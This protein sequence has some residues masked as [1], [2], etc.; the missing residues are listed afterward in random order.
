[1]WFSHFLSYGMFLVWFQLSFLIL[2]YVC[3]DCV[4]L[5]PI[6]RK[7][8]TIT[9]TS[10]YKWNIL[11]FLLFCYCGVSSGLYRLYHSI[12]RSFSDMKS[13]LIIFKSF[14]SLLVCRMYYTHWQLFWQYFWLFQAG[15][16]SS[17]EF[18]FTHSWIIFTLND[19]S[20]IRSHS[21]FG[22]EVTLFYV[23]SLSIVDEQTQPLAIC[24]NKWQIIIKSG[25]ITNRFD[26]E[27]HPNRLFQK[28]IDPRC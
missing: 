21:S 17:I 2:P 10:K 6:T 14:S 13:C 28:Q 23:P 11:L 26:S 19:F 1:M 18:V 27:P 20:L 12:R 16:A 9:K 25:Y 8:K 24:N 7:L 15:F 3:F 4:K 5:Q 22:S